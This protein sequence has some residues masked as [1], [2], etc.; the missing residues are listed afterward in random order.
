MDVFRLIFFTAVAVTAIALMRSI[1]ALA[2]LRLWRRL[3]RNPSVAVRDLQQ[4]SVIVKG[5]VK[6]IGEPL[7]LPA[8]EESCVAYEIAEP[9]R[10]GSTRQSAAFAVEDATGSVEVRGAQMRVGAPVDRVLYVDSIG[11]KTLPGLG[12]PMRVLREGDEVLLVGMAQREADV[13]GE[14]GGYRDAPTKL[15]IRA[16]GPVG[17][18]AVRDAS[19]LIR[20]A[21]PTLVVTTI[22]VAAALASVGVGAWA[23]VFGLK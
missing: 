9:I 3:T 21:A 23:F 15:V 20:Y 18:A 17:L 4:G 1:R 2:D 14:A 13:S 12:R 6:L 10:F 11:M 19:S 22:V 8:S 16:G 5:R 7:K